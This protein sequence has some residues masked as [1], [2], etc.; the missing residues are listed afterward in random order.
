[1]RGI[2][3][4]PDGF[5]KT[6]HLGSRICLRRVVVWLLDSYRCDDSSEVGAAHD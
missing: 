3:L 2:D 4:V 6:A 1:M 5:G